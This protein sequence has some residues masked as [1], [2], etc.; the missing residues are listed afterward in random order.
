MFRS[1]YECLDQSDSSDIGKNQ[2][3]VRMKGN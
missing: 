3:V 2:Q 1:G